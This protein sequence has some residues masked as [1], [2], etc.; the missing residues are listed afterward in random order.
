VTTIRSLADIE[1][2]EAT[3]LK[4]RLKHRSVFEGIADTAARF[5]ERPAIHFFLEGDGFAQPVSVSYAELIARIRQ[6]ANLLIDLGV[7]EGEVVSILLP[8]LPHS[9]YAIWGAEAVAVANPI[10]PLLEPWQIRDI[11]RAA[12]TK[13]L[14]TLGEVSGSDIW[15]KV[16]S[17]RTQ[18]PSLEAIVRVGGGGE[19]RRRIFGFDEATGGQPQ[20]TLKRARV[21][22]PADVVSLFHTGGTTGTPKLAR[23]THENEA[24]LCWALNFL[25]GCTPQDVLLCGLPLF[26]VNG[27]FVTGAAPFTAGASVVILT[28]RG[29]RDPAVIRNFFRIVERYGATFF[30][31]VPTVLAALLQVPIEDSYLSSL[32]FAICGAAPMP[33][34]LF[35]EFER[36]TG[37]K[38][39]EGYGLT[40]GACVSSINP[41]EGERVVGSIGLRVP[42]QDMRVVELDSQG[43]WLRE[44]GENEVGSILIKGPNVFPGYVDERHNQAIWAAEGWLNT[45]DLGRRDSRGYFYITGR[46]KDLIIRGGHNIDPAAIEGPLHEHPAVALAAA[47]GRPHPYAGEVPVAYVELRPNANVTEEEL[48]AH[49]RKRVGERAAIPKEIR[50]VERMP[51]SAV[52]KI[53]KPALRHDALRRAL[54]EDLSRLGEKVGRAE[55]EVG[56]DKLHGTAARVRVEPGIG[57]SRAW[58]HSELTQTFGRYAVHIEIEVS[59]P[60]DEVS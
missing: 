29:F 20:A 41:R 59:K 38:I 21:P 18:V 10:N 1:A 24:F 5:P 32:R 39:L 48:L 40:E 9:H 53:F 43:R 30:S 56:E 33:L 47:V 19:E 45:G 31:C 51:L 2:V 58:L 60:R 34:E 6:L 3:P 27:V 15:Q 46:K 42:Y 57:V 37:I 49:C 4:E 54:E 23:H 11:M 13:V 44:C 55:V 8:N 14:I 25:S 36:R 12:R 35:R 26:H 50:I 17:I 28:P 7:K 22:K 52:G 16:E